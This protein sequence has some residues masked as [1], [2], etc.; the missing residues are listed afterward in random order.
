M[1]T[2]REFL[3]KSFLG[4]SAASA[5]GLPAAAG[6]PG[7]E[8]VRAAL[9]WGAA[10]GAAK[11]KV[12]IL[13]AG[14]AGMVAAQELLKAG[15]DVTI[16]EG[17]VRP[18]G[19]VHTLRE[20][21]SDGLYAEAGA[22]RIPEWHDLTLRY[23]RE[24]GLEAELE[25]YRPASG[26][27]ITFLRGKRIR[28]KV[29]EALPLAGLPFE[30]SAEERGGT[31]DS[32]EA[33][34]WDPYLKLVGNPTAP[35]WPSPEAAALDSMTWLEAMRRKGASK[36]AVDFALAQTGFAED[37]A[38]DF[39][40]DQ[41]GHR[42]AKSMSRI[43][44]G[45]DRLTRAMAAK[46][47]EK[48]RYGAEAVRIEQRETAVRVTCREWSGQHAIEADRVICTI[49]FPVLR[50]LEIAP[51]FSAAKQEVIE[52]LYLDPVVR[53]YAQARRRFWED[54]GLNG[55]AS[56]DDGV[57][58]W[59]PTFSQPGRRGILH[60]YFGDGLGAKVVA[61]PV[62]DRV[63]HSM[64]VMERVFPGLA[65]HTE[66][67]YQWCWADEPFARGAYTVLN[68]GQVIGWSKLIRQPEGRI[69]FAGEHAS[70]FPGWMQ[71]AIESG[72]RAAREVHAA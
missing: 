42:G 21:F 16:L 68:V 43:R 52:K 25:P 10:E 58:I 15:H 35:D 20:P 4:A 24:F 29:G 31:S 54:D 1:L 26:T 47:G 41:L 55:F 46:L 28:L 6:L 69:H 48:I 57:E 61:V 40:R 44:G 50:R 64:N 9:S 72:L 13:G 11:K 62:A 53:V 3:W 34:Y 17:S 59:Q 23:V 19:R 5:W 71:G 37:S 65:E 70:A 56:A 49:P 12:L 51:R 27:E 66:G 32:L 30:F 39:F 60:T 36:G 7:V 14:L 8:V 63:A 38:L 2:R 45:N 67:T 22:G 18:G 33:K